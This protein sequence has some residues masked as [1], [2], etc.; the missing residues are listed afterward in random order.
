MKS[1]SP[2]LRDGLNA[3]YCEVK[4]REVWRVAIRLL[5]LLGVE[6]IRR[7]LTDMRHEPIPAPVCKS[8][9][10]TGPLHLKGPQRCEV[11]TQ[12]DGAMGV[13][14]CGQGQVWWGIDMSLILARGN[15]HIS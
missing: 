7:L 15:T 4:D 11:W 10:A 9:P 5:G 13:K 8:G 2:L 14:T 6:E 12:R 3:Q 1:G